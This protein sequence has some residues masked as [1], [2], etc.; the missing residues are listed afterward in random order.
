MTDVPLHRDY[1]FWSFASG[2]QSLVGWLVLGSFTK[3]SKVQPRHIYYI[4]GFQPLIANHSTPV[5]RVQHE[6]E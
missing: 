2:M 4:S 5:L 3:R 1:L 6:V